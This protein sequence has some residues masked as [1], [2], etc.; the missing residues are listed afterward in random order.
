MLTLRQRF[1]LNVLRQWGPSR[2]LPGHLTTY[3]LLKT[4]ALLLMVI[5]H[6]GVFIFP[7]WE[8]LRIVGRWSL[9]IWG[10]LIG[11]SRSQRFDRWLIIGAV[12]LV[13]VDMVIKSPVFPLNILWTLL[14][15]RLWCLFLWHQELDW[16][17]VAMVVIL[18]IC[19]Y[20]ITMPFFEYGTLAMLF[21][22]LGVIAR[23]K[24]QAHMMIGIIS[25]IAAI[26][27]G[28]MQQFAFQFDLIG[29]IIMIIGCMS[30][31]LGLLFFQGKSLNYPDTL[32]WVR[33]LQWTGRHTLAFYIVHWLILLTIHV[34]HYPV[35]YTSF[36]WFR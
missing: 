8:G 36:R 33:I 15:C 14:F 31:T 11:Y 27:Y 7:S 34:W 16:Q 3:D 18:S 32:W 13:V 30:V 6:M 10:F 12:F 9:P 29:A 26:F 35:F 23:A 1:S 20:P 2:D 24:P 21:A 22:I 19:C 17:R 28:V 25:G 5:D 4:F